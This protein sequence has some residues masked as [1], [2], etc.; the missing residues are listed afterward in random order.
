MTVLRY[1]T[2]GNCKERIEAR[3][4]SLEPGQWVFR[5]VRRYTLDDPTATEDRFTLRTTLPLAHGGAS[6]DTFPSVEHRGDEFR[7]I[8]DEGRR[9]V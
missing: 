4:A 1:D 9:T 6:F 5:D 7:R 3:E 2:A 8:V